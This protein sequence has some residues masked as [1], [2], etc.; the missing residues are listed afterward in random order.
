MLG[1]ISGMLSSL[2]FNNILGYY[3]R[4]LESSVNLDGFLDIIVCVS[5]CFI[6]WQ[7]LALLCGCRKLA[8]VI[9][10][11][12]SV[13][14]VCYILFSICPKDNGLLITERNIFNKI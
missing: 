3:V 2:A 1:A 10:V 6:M 5:A 7:A 11:K 14:I 8:N 12:L 9:T 13:A 4:I